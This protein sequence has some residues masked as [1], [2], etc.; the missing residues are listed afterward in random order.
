MR[1]MLV[2][3]AII[4]LSLRAEAYCD[5][6]REVSTHQA[7][8]DLLTAIFAHV[9]YGTQPAPSFRPRH[10]PEIFRSLPEGWA[11]LFYRLSTEDEM[12]FGAKQICLADRRP[13][14]FICA[15]LL[16]KG[17]VVASSH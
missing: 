5:L 11:L 13:P 6:G 1:L 3:P 15:W 9:V 2:L 16:A 17:G 14:Q 4:A 7:Q 10:L 8:D 12:D